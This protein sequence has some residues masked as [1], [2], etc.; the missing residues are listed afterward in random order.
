MQSEPAC[1]SVVRICDAGP[2]APSVLAVP[3]AGGSAQPF[4]AWKPL[5][6]GRVSLWALELPGRGRCFG[7]PM[8]SSLVALAQGLAHTLHAHGV[9]PDLVFGHSLGALISFELLRAMR[10][11]GRGLPAAA[12][13]TGRIAPSK[14]TAFGLPRFTRGD[15]ID[16]LRDLGGTPDSVLHNDAVIDMMLPVLQGDLELIASHEHRPAAPLDLD[17]AVAGGFD[18]RR[19]PIDGLLAWQQAFSGDFSLHM[20]PGGHFFI[21]EDRPALA[22]LLCGLAGRAALRSEAA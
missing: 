20:F 14:P 17:L 22:E 5:L 2:R 15:L 16:Y 12:M 19:V 1:G 10:A 13:M 6:E 8:P 3:Y 9:Q 7:Q 4:F 18:D 11:H 21:E